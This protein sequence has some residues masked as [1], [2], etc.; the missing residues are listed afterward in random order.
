MKAT[1][2]IRGS[3]RGQPAEKGELETKKSSSRGR[4]KVRTQ[5][6]APSAK[7]KRGVD[8]RAVEALQFAK[9]L[10]DKGLDW[11]TIGNALFGIG[12]KLT[13]LFPDVRER[14]AL[15][16]SRPYKELCA[17]LDQERD[18]YGD[19]PGELA[20][21][22]STASGQT[23]VRMPRSMHAALLAEAEAEGVSLNQLCVSKLAMQL[24]GV[25]QLGK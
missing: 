2:R 25:V 13:Q 6:P 11:I 14:A 24:R 7:S 1:S 21:K 12:G 9:E 15:A 10:A 19:P 22:W 8:A 20:G 3:S 4:A 17:L 23:I 16:G 5:G 18:D